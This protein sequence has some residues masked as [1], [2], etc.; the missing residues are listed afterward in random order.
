MKKI[1]NNNPVIHQVIGKFDDAYYHH[2]TIVKVETE[3]KQR[4]HD[5][6]DNI[7]II[8][9]DVSNGLIGGYCGKARYEGGP[10]FLPST[11]NCVREEDVVN[12]IAH[13]LGHALNLHHDFRDV[14][15]IMAKGGPQRTQF[16]ECSA[17]L[18]SVSHF[19]NKVTHT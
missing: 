12:L 5:V 13:E 16:S 15:Y 6:D 18:L 1:A 14:K 11:G 17:M 9:I 3:I 8:S 7:Y 4:F 2:N 19:L 10:V